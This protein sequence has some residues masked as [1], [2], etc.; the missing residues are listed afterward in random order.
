MSVSIVGTVR[1][2]FLKLLLFLLTYM[3]GRLASCPS[4]GLIGR[5]GGRQCWPPEAGDAAGKLPARG[6]TRSAGRLCETAGDAGWQGKIALLLMVATKSIRF[7]GSR[8]RC[9]VWRRRIICLLLVYGISTPKVP[10]KLSTSQPEIEMNRPHKYHHVTIR[11]LSSPRR[12]LARSRET[13]RMCGT[14]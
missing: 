9:R 13:P 5:N 14:F 6:I 10:S 11:Q 7:L 2:A 3:Q 8:F 12:T 1:E 4:I